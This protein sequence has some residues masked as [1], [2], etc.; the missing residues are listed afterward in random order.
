MISICDVSTAEAHR[1]TRCLGESNFILTEDEDGV[2]PKISCKENVS[3]AF[4]A[5]YGYVLLETDIGQF[6]LHTNHFSTITII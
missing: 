4:S 2:T 6:E 3:I 5:K 1:L